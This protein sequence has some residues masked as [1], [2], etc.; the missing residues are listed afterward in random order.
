MLLS[1]ESAAFTLHR[2]NLRS[3]YFGTKRPSHSQQIRE[4]PDSTV[5]A[6]GPSMCCNIHRS[7]SPNLASLTRELPIADSRGGVVSLHR[8]G[9]QPLDASTYQASIGFACRKLMYM[10]NDELSKSATHGTPER[11]WGLTNH[12]SACPAQRRRT[13][14]SHDAFS[15]IKIS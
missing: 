14:D 6:V 1:H 12:R 11:R 2:S 13:H 9:G 10:I 4:D 15:I 5:V 7:G 3:G 8:I